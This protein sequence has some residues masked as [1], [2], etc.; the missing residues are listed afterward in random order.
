MN[1]VFGASKGED[2]ERVK[3]FFN[4]HLKELADMVIKQRIIY[5]EEARENIKE[6]FKHPKLFEVKYL[7]NTTPAEINIWLD[8]VMI[9]LLTKN[10]TVVLI[11]NK[12]VADS[13]RQYFE[14]MWMIAKY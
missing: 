9:V 4:K 1:Y 5:N 6:Q 7:E 14:V 13:F 2:E 12:K 10:P 3:I 8:K 11:S